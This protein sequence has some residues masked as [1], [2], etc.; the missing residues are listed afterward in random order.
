[1][2][3]DHVQIPECRCLSCGR[4]M[5]ALGTPDG[6]EAKPAPGDIAVCLRCG[7]VMKL[8]ENLKL[9][10]MTEAEM[11]EL[12]A[13]QAWMDEVAQLVGAIHFLKHMAG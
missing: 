2:G 4:P 7:A 13:D 9:R 5:D 6:A 10:G 3:K 11:D 1:M 8:D 12:V